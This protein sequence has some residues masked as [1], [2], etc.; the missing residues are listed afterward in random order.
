MIYVRGD[1]HGQILNSFNAHDHPEYKKLTKND[2]F[3]ILG[4]CGVP[5]N[6]CFKKEDKYKLNW[7]NSKPWKTVFLLGNHDNW[8][9]A[10]SLPK[11]ETEI[12][13]V[14][15]CVFEGQEFEDI[16]VIADPSVLN[17]EG[18]QC[19]FIPG[20]ECHDDPHVFTDANGHAHSKLPILHQEPKKHFTYM[21]GS[22]DADM[23]EINK[24]FRI[25][26]NKPQIYRTAG[27][28]WWPNE[29]INVDAAGEI[30]YYLTDN[31]CHIDYVFTHDC[32]AIQL[33]EI[34]KKL[35]NGYKECYTEGELFLDRVRTELDFD[36]WYHGHLHYD[37]LVP[38]G[39]S[40][41]CGL[42]HTVLDLTNG[43]IIGD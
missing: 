2:Y 20:A 12:G 15:Q 23:D 40:R 41:I 19:F 39:D 6:H 21:D 1:V 38:N 4:D 43:F 28:D 37:M 25:Y 33:R 35:P 3:I 5:W 24:N 42:Y 32:P 18:K 31:D 26:Y 27:K 9:W 30:L 11:K 34:N 13:I 29:A 7:L 10:L 17:I 8:D 22:T 14:R 16:Y 36:E